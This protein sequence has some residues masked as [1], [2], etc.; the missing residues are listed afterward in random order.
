MLSTDDEI[1]RNLVLPDGC[2]VSTVQGKD[3][4]YSFDYRIS[5]LKALA[6]SLGL[7]GRSAEKKVPAP[8]MV[9]SVADR[10]ALWQ[11]LLDTDGTPSGTGVEFSSVSQELA[12][13]VVDL[14]R[15]LGG[16]ASVRKKPVTG[17][18]L[19]DGEFRR[20]QD[21]YRVYVQPPVGVAPFRLLRKRE[22]YTP[23]STQR[24]TRTIRS[25]TP[26]HTE[27]ARCIRVAADDH[28]YVTRDFVVTHNTIHAAGLVAMLLETGEI[29]TKGRAVIVPRSPALGQWYEQ[30]LR[31]IPDLNVIVAT[32]TR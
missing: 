19:P 1:V 26:S 11:G 22:K 15:S 14:T 4:D 21:S 30:L 8:Y 20:T 13:N 9:A 3:V 28:L 10:I 6:T 32:G 29:P 31:M 7:R 18:R 5:G 23:K 2:T 17:Y 25:I 16:L 12:Q 24:L 27:Q